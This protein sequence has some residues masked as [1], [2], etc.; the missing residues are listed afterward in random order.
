MANRMLPLHVSEPY[1]AK[2]VRQCRLACKM[3]KVME[4]AD[5]TRNTTEPLKRVAHGRRYQ[6]V[7]DLI[8]RPVEADTVL[9]YGCGDGHLFSYFI[10]QLSRTKLVGYD[11]DPKLLSQ[12]SSAV[13]AGAQLT[14]D[15]DA[16]MTERRGAF[17]LIYCVEVCEHLTDK[18]LVQLFRNIR[19]LAAPQARVIIGVPIETGP[20]GFLKALYRMSKGGRQSA[21]LE[22]ALRS[23][24]NAKIAREVTDVEWFGSH[25]GFSHN[26]F[27]KILQQNKFEV[28]KTY[29]L[30]FPLMRSV[31]NNEI[32][33][34]CRKMP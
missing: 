9:D 7:V 20:S 19:T 33:F 3:G 5:Y 34:V 22:K 6:Q 8:A 12:A 21:N 32:Y 14:T 2:K 23:L 27:R 26:N 11:P 16:L 31:M 4:Y 17:S 29:H 1:D 18:A 28:R 30:P 13:S 24:V 15:I 10:G 25:T